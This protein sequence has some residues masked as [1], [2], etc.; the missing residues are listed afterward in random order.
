[1]SQQR[2]H[3]LIIQND[4][5]DAALIRQ[6]INR[7]P[8]EVDLETICN[9]EQLQACLDGSKPDFIISAYSLTGFSGIGALQLARAQYPKLPFIIVSEN[10]ETE[11]AIDLMLEGASDCIR[12]DNLTR[13]HVAVPREI[14]KYRQ[15]L[16]NK[17]KLR[18]AKQRE[19]TIINS[20]D[21][22]VWEA[23]AQTFEFTFISQKV[24][25]I[26]GYPPDQWLNTPQFWQDHIHPEDRSQA[27]TYCHQKTQQGEHHEFEYRMR[28]A[29]GK[30]VWLRD[31]VTVILDDGEP[32]QLRG[33]MVDVTEQKELQDLL[34]RT[35]RLAQV[36]SWEIDFSEQEEGEVYWSDMTK[37]LLEV[38]ADYKPTVEDTLSFI[39]PQSRKQ[40]ENDFKQAVSQGKPYD[41]E[42]LVE[43]GK[44][45]KLWIR[46]IG[47]AEFKDRECIRV[48]GS[49]QDIT[50]RKRS[51]KK[52]REIFDLSP[53]PV[54]VYD[55]QTLQFLD[56]NQAAIE[57][58][59]Y[60]RAEFLAMTLK[61]IRP[62]DDIPELLEATRQPPNHKDHYFE[63]QFRHQTKDGT[64]IQVNIKRNSIEYNG[65]TASMVLAE[66]VTE[67]R[68]AQH[69]LKLSEQK[70]K[71]L[72]QS[73][74]SMIAVLDEHGI[75]RYASD[76]YK[77]ITGWTSW[78]LLGQDAFAY[79]H[80]EDRD[81][82][83]QA[84]DNLQS[85]E[86]NQH[87]LPFRFKHK[88]GHWIW[89]ESIGSDLSDDGIID[90]YVI[91]CHEVTDRQ[92][93]TQMEKIE[94]DILEK[95]TIGEVE[96]S[97]LAEELL[98]K[99]E[100]LHPR[101]RC[102]LQRIV[103]GRLYPLAAPSL[104]PEYVEAIEDLTIGPNAGACGTAAYQ[105]EPVISENIFE[106]PQWE[107]YRH[108]GRKYN[109]SACWSQPVLGHNQQVIA[110]F[111]I[112][113]KNQHHPSHRERNTID[114]VVHL[115]RLLFDSFEKAKAEQELALREQRFK[116]LVQDGSDLIAIL[117]KEANYTYVAPSSESILGISPDE[118]IGTNAFDYIHDDH[119][120]RVQQT[121]SSLSSGQRV[122][123]DP[124]LFKNNKGEWRWIATVIT[125]LLDNPAVEGYVAN[126][127][128]V[129][130]Q[131]ER[132][133]KLKESLERYEYVTR[134]TEDIV[135]DWDIQRDTLK[136]DDSYSE[137]FCHTNGQEVFNIGQWAQNVHPDDLA[138][139]QESLESTL[140]DSSATEWNAEYR[141][142]LADGTYVHILERGFI[143]RDTE[144][145][146]VRMI[147]AL[148]DITRLKQQ[149]QELREALGEKETLLTE[150]HHRVKNNL[151]VVSG[152]MQ[153][154]AFEVDHPQV[155]NKLLDGVSRIKSMATIH[156]ML[157][158]SSTFTR[159]MFSEVVKELATS[160][161]K[162]LTNDVEVTWKLDLDP[163]ILNVNHAI[164]CSLIINEVITNS[165]KHGLKGRQ[166]GMISIS[167]RQ[168]KEK[169]QLT[170]VDN[171][172]GVPEG[173][174]NSKT[175]SLGLLLI[176]QL[177]NQLEGTY[178]YE[179][180]TEGLS[181]RLEFKKGDVKGVG[182]SAFTKTEH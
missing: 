41:N 170:I 95:N 114:R 126:S 113:Y 159:L 151:A 96:L 129:T 168:R 164:P 137:K 117:D 152:M 56:V 127:R 64:L 75:F 180:L 18:Q 31:Y 116:S 60:T 122:T 171:G 3:I 57:H 88:E 106:D 74:A 2:Y 167:L 29:Q 6:E 111:A 140:S 63:G 123:T 51:E 161:I 154:Q 27:V 131:K 102:S 181:F 125:N 82:I 42:L 87:T 133:Q 30:Y 172:V 68:Q 59:G 94:R 148:Q 120:S 21:G 165:I 26:L 174:D 109:F 124:F 39:E 25:S 141:F 77:Q 10:I 12:K 5:V 173:F 50:D 46:N 132:E 62:E 4:E 121:L 66:D 176:R 8:L 52:Y 28:D 99:L 103:N 162:T 73:G 175:T 84:F 86:G 110:T 61:D 119:T 142:A 91:N 80:P 47:Q 156:E 115:L 40:A 55:P 160:V 85:Q 150:I 78:E 15:Y 49:F 135:Y 145:E 23:D 17:Q 69:E 92:Y 93:Y 71:S 118:F 107:G 166:N 147:G 9:K 7:L 65:Q 157:Y 76:N 14:Q 163:V 81:R 36:G 83:Q 1:M 179:P 13:L 45:N 104:P 70:F 153:L 37:E 20:V 16:E 24:E 34:H 182:S 89:K 48:Y 139:T 146:A 97:G 130:D 19:Q 128:D 149:E 33:I 136:W 53:Q 134:A 143:I 112:Y 158:Q 67:K 178:Q 100:T 58:Y 22:I 155:K 79:M 144:G 138:T 35:N 90:G 32:D 101:M 169:V 72:V 108:L 44:G 177:T 98:Q 54:W 38:K 43:T 11:T 105:K